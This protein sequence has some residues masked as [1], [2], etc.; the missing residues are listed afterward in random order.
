MDKSKVMVIFQRF[1]QCTLN[2]SGDPVEKME[3]F[4]CLGVLFMSDGGMDTELLP[5][6]GRASAVV[7]EHGRGLVGKTELGRSSEL[8]VFH[9][10]SYPH[11]W[12][13]D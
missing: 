8:S 12:L 1:V 10:H 9:V 11:L 2:V 4:K 13:W 5:R 7:R 3:K 6:I